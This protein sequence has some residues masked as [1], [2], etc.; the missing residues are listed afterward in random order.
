MQ[1]GQVICNT[2]LIGFEVYKLKGKDRGTDEERSGG[3]LVLRYR[4]LDVSG[5]SRG[6]CTRR[7]A[8]RRSRAERRANTAASPRRRAQATAPSTQRQPAFE[9]THASTGNPASRLRPDRP[10]STNTRHANS[11]SVGYPSDKSRPAMKQRHLSESVRWQVL[12]N[13]RLRLDVRNET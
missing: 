3:A 13:Q 7:R 8:A 4:P 1:E 11:S 6:A 12:K 10:H 2:T 5:L 9:P